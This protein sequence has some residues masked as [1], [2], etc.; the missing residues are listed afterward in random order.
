[1]GR[2]HN[3]YVSRASRQ[4]PRRRRLTIISLVAIGEVCNFAAYAFAPAILVTPL[5]ALSVLIGA[6][7]GSYFLKEELGTLGRL[8]SAICLIGAVIIVLHAPPDEDI[9]TIDEILHYAIQPGSSQ[10]RVQITPGFA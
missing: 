2:H 3:V 4:P 8:G 9:Q 5:G 1:V 10:F 7:L 6:V